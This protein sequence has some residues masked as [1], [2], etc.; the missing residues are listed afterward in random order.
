MSTLLDEIRGKAKA[1]NKKIML[2][3]GEEPRIIEAAKI[4]TKEKIARVVLVGNPQKIKELGGDLDGIEIVDPSADKNREK[5]VEILYETRKSKGLTYEQAE[6]LALDPLYYSV[7]ALKAA[8]ADGMVGGAIHSTGDT[9]RPALQII[10]AAPGIKT[11][12]SFFLMILEGSKYGY[13]GAFLFADCGLNVNPDA[14]QLAEIAVTSAKNAKIL[15]G[16]EPHVAMLSFSTKGSAKHELVD[17]VVLATQ[18][19]KELDP[20]LKIDGELQADAALVESVAKL[21]CPGSEVAG[22]ANVLIFPDLN[23]GNIAYKLVQRLA[24]AIA[25]GP[26]CQGFNKP[27]NDLSRGCSVQDVVDAVAITAVQATM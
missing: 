8:D 7:L 27:V 2:P 19:A 21:K 26:I 16:M 17:K 6:K 25:I 23:S 9:L 22:K 24:N 1:A 12:S 3:E 11:I 15:T 18:K 14:E 10:K 13:N 20:S 5:Y 4:I